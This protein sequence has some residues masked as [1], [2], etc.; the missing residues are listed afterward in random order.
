MAVLVTKA[1]LSFD[2]AALKKVAKVC[3]YLTVL[4]CLTE[5]II[6]T[7]LASTVLNWSGLGKVECYLFGTAL[8]C[9]LGAV[10]PAVIV[11]AM[12]N[13]KERGYLELQKNRE[14]SN[15]VIAASSFDDI[16][17]ISCF[18]L[19]LGVLVESEGQS[20]LW[21]FFK[22]PLFVIAGIFIGMILGKLLA[23][24]VARS[25]T[26][27]VFLGLTFS[28]CF[29]QLMI[30]LDTPAA[31]PLGCIV[32]GLVCKLQFE[33]C[34][35]RLGKVLDVLW[36]VLEPTM[37][38][39]IGAEVDLQNVGSSILLRA[40]ILL[41]ISLILRTLVAFSVAKR[42]TQFSNSESMFIAFSWLP[43]ATVQAAIGSTAFD[44]F[45]ASENS[46]KLTPAKDI[47]TMAVLSI[48]I[49]APLGSVLMRSTASKLLE[50]NKCIE[51]I[52]LKSSDGHSVGQ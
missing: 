48:F 1:G 9:V 37:F 21:T 8:G 32:F 11:P 36:N 3:V 43:K 49:T 34:E 18:M 22:G 42:S 15:L 44:R 16:M 27:S 12:E 28:F 47:L 51:D 33:I 23:G 35:E 41:S 29:N 5:I 10:T 25:K 50:K 46:A 7:F 24:A 19:I 45:S 4:P 6:C 13:L 2:L 52:E 26:F 30:V 17:A 20:L 38:C 14:M 40:F 39:L 31:G